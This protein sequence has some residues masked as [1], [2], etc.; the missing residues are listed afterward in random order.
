[1]CFRTCRFQ[2]WNRR[3]RKERQGTQHGHKTVVDFSLTKPL[4]LAT[5]G[6]IRTYLKSQTIEWHGV[7]QIAF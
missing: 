2:S 5:F 7:R 4:Y 3:L 1:M 6:V